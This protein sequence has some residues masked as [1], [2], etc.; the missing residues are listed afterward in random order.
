MEKFL[1]ELAELC[2]KHNMS[3][4]AD[5]YDGSIWVSPVDL[6]F[7]NA[8]KCDSAAEAFP[9]GV[10]DYEQITNFLTDKKGK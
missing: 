8:R 2:K 7:G 9:N 6:K 1:E 10:L 3:I 4:F 5:N